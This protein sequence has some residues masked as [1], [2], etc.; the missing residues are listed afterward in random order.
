M[1]RDAAAFC[2]LREMKWRPLPEDYAM[3]K[4]NSSMQLTRAADYAVRVM[5]HLAQAPEGGRLSLP[6]LSEAADAP[7]SFLS[8]V[9]QSLA[10]AGLVSSR[11][12]QAGGFQITPRGRNAAMLDVIQAIDGPI[13]LNVCL[14][15]GRS[16][17]RK[18]HCTA[19][20]VWVRA[21]KAMVDVLSSVTVRKMAAD[22]STMR[23]VHA[24]HRD[25]AAV[26]QNTQLIAAA[27]SR[28]DGHRRCWNCGSEIESHIDAPASVLRIT[29]P[30]PGRA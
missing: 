13:F 7:E 15:S 21:Q 28:G 22:S 11:R 30:Q 26:Q 24:S 12:G 4:P 9:L 23:G 29:A 19:H 16:C 18:A 1:T 5:I 27:P 2:N 20:P 25:R 3:K 14:V 6:E 17:H 8:K 10:H